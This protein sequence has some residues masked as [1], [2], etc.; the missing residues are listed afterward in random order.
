L[1]GKKS[2]TCSAS[3]KVLLACPFL[4]LFEVVFQIG[5]KSRKRPAASSSYEAEIGKSKI[6][7][8]DSTKRPENLICFCRKGTL[9]EKI[10]KICKFP[11][12]ICHSKVFSLVFVLA[13]KK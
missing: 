6:R 7:F 1:F 12:F 4:T 9:K 5:G 2:V 13:G 3:L 10:V 8:E 11:Q